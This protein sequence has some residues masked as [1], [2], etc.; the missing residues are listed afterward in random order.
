MARWGTAALFCECLNL[1]PLAEENPILSFLLQ[2]AVQ[3]TASCYGSAAPSLPLIVIYPLLLSMAVTHCHSPA[4]YATAQWFL[5]VMQCTAKD[6]SQGHR[7]SQN[8]RGKWLKHCCPYQS[9]F[10]S[11][12]TTKYKRKKILSYQQETFPDNPELV[13]GHSTWQQRCFLIMS[14]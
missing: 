3:G 1:D 13:S 8:S 7:V 11:T 14:L 4:A 5:T 2:I 6:I 9:D 12:N 10:M